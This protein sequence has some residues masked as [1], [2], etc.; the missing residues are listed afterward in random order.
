MFSVHEVYPLN[1]QRS[2][3]SLKTVLEQVR[4]LLETHP[5]GV[6]FDEIHSVK[7]LLYG[8]IER[9]GVILERFSYSQRLLRELLQI[10]TMHADLKSHEQKLGLQI[11]E[12]LSERL[13]IP[14]TGE[15]FT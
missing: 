4:K 10:V 9:F 2:Y 5:S 7:S 8:T 1:S 14:N 6:S 15:Y 3:D 13:S 12:E 11:L